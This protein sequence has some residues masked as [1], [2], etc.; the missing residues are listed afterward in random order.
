MS[1]RNPSTSTSTST[2]SPLADLWYVIRELV[3]PHGRIMEICEWSPD[4]RWVLDVDRITRKEWRGYGRRVILET[5]LNSGTGWRVWMKLPDGDIMGVTA[6]CEAEIQPDG[7]AV[8]VIK[9]PEDPD[10][11]PEYPRKVAFRL[12][13]RFMSEYCREWAARDADDRHAH[14][15]GDVRE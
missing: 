3:H 13:E 9:L 10:E 12:A 7:G 4:G 2:D 8:M 15:R 6:E 5:E 14:P 11:L 1:V